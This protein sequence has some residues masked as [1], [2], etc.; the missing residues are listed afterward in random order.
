MGMCNVYIC[1]ET[2]KQWRQ[3]SSLACRYESIYIWKWKVEGSTHACMWNVKQHTNKY[4]H[5][6][7]QSDLRQN[8]NKPSLFEL[9]TETE[10]VIEVEMEIEIELS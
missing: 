9:Q 4:K 7:K 5:C 8:Q 10:I 6:I 2:I 3:L 1:L